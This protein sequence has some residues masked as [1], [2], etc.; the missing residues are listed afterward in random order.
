MGLGE[1][2]LLWLVCCRHSCIYMVFL[3]LTYSLTDFSLQLMPIVSSFSCTSPEFISIF[4]L[5]Y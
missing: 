1:S 2:S 3:H 5:P 4:S